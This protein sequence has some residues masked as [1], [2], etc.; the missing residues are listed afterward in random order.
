I[1][2]AIGAYDLALE[3]TL[4]WQRDQQLVCP[5]HH[6]GVG[7]D[8]TIGAENEPGPHSTW[9]RFV[10]GPWLLARSRWRKTWRHGNAKTPKELQHLLICA[11]AGTR[12]G[13]RTFQR[14][15]V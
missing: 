3:F 1:G 13:C 12:A 2:T 4:V 10:I 5:V 14:S 7:H 6:M 11:R 15:N 9:S 8:Q